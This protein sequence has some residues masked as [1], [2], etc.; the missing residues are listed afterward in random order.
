[1]TVYRVASSLS[2]QQMHQQTIDALDLSSTK[3]SFYSQYMAYQP[4][5]LVALLQ[6][7]PLL[8][9]ISQEPLSLENPS[10]LPAPVAGQIVIVTFEKQAFQQ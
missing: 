9:K 5:Q 4:D 7:N 1:M 2:N 6:T 8:S 10:A 3:Y